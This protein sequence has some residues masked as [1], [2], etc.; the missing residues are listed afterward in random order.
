MSIMPDIYIKRDIEQQLI[1]WKNSERHAVAELSGARQ[2]GKT[3]VLRHF[4]NDNY[5]NCIYINLASKNESLL[6][7]RYI[8]E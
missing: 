1:A 6:F 7:L 8:D 4:G 5:N 2:T 3:T